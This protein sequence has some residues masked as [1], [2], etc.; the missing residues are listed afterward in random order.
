MMSLR[1]ECDE[2]SRT[3]GTAL[4]TIESLRQKLGDARADLADSVSVV[5]A[6]GVVLSLAF[7]FTTLRTSVAERTDF[8]NGVAA[9]VL[10]D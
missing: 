10:R 5:F 6:C 9:G 3:S 1:A 4:S 8:G 7:T 2:H